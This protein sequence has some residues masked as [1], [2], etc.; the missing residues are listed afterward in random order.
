[1]KMESSLTAKITVF[2]F[3]VVAVDA[4]ILYEWSLP[5]PEAGILKLILSDTETESLRLMQDL[6]TIFMNWSIGVIAAI[7]F[8]LKLSLGNDT[9]LKKIDLGLFSLTLMFAVG[10]L[11]FGHLVLDRSIIFLSVQQ[12]PMRDSLIHNLRLYQYVTGLAAIAMFALSVFSYFWS[13]ASK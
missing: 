10:S 4:A 13:R 9:T 5:D 2:V 8:F 1:M 12:Y 7:A 6:V 3:L 11:Y